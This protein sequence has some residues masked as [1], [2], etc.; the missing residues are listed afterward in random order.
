MIPQETKSL[1]NTK[2]LIEHLLLFI[3]IMN[4]SLIEKID[5]YKIILK[6]HTQQK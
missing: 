1:I 2:N 3:Q 6:N 4:L 5:K